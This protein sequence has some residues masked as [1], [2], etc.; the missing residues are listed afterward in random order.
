MAQPKRL[1]ELRRRKPTEWLQSH[2]GPNPRILAHQ[3]QRPTGV[4]LVQRIPNQ[5]QWAGEI[6]PRP[7]WFLAK[8]IFR[9][10]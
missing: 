9:V 8:P 4:D 5:T 6:T 7:S 10:I 2:G 1:T 3:A